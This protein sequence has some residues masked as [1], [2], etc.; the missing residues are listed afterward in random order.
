[1]DRKWQQLEDTF[2][3]WYDN[4]FTPT[5]SL[6]NHLRHDVTMYAVTQLDCFVIKTCKQNVHYPWQLSPHISVLCQNL[7]RQETSLGL[8]WQWSVVASS[9]CHLPLCLTTNTATAAYDVHDCTHFTCHKCFL[10]KLWSVQIM[11]IV[12]QLQQIP[13]IIVL[14]E[15]HIRKINCPL[16]IEDAKSV[17]YIYIYLYSP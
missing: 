12:D 8:F 13:N 7:Q 5:H 10:Q 16:H 4:K 17:I 9:S 15:N 1:V 14:V 11:V 6:D 2:H 3:Y